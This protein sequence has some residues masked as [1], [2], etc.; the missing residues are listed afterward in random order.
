M[1]YL[2]ILL[3]LALIISPLLWFRQSPR[4]KMITEMRRLASSRGLRVRLV[5][6]P[7]AREGEGRLEYAGYTLLWVPD[8]S[9]SPFS[10][11]EKWLLVRGTRRGGHSPWENWQ[12]LGHEANDRLQPVIGAVLAALPTDVIAVEVNR[13]GVA[14]VWQER[15]ELA[16]IDRID[17]QLKHL[18]SAIRPDE[19]FDRLAAE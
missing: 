7:D 2:L 3:I 11:M 6:A 19:S 14:I 9:P 15:G 10:R 8:S 16:D 18:R 12:W 13:E 5:H 4:Q 17:T 1:T